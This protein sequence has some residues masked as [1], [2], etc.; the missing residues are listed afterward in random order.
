MHSYT[1]SMTTEKDFV[2]MFQFNPTTR[3]L[4]LTPRVMQ[5]LVKG[6]MCP[7]FETETLTFEIVSD[8]L[9]TSSHDFTFKVKPAKKIDETNLFI[10]DGNW[11]E[12]IPP[13]EPDAAKLELFESKVSETGLLTIK[14]NK[15]IVVDERIWP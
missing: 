1:I 10:F 15:K 8:L 4:K 2:G 7:S 12:R 14:F 6:N 3:I 13:L 11:E 9:G 5:N